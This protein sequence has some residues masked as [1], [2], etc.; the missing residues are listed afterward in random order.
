M[1]F[2]IGLSIYLWDI[3]FGVAIP[4]IFVTLASM[5][6]YTVSTLLPLFYEFC[7]YNTTISKM[8]QQLYQ[9]LSDKGNQPGDENPE[10]DIITGQALCWL[11]V[12][13]E[14][15]RSVDIALQ[16][17]AG[18]NKNLPR[19]LLQEC[20]AEMLIYQR[21]T[22]SSSYAGN[23]D[24]AVSLYARALSFLR[25]NRQGV[26]P[27]DR[28]LETSGKIQVSVWAMQSKNER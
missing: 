23:C 8:G 1:L 16:A 21:L 12:N 7:P 22:A 10:Q 9:T 24:L 14:V 3:N 4:V 15:P 2:A 18:A 6:F 17:I 26:N 25:S 13:C 20:N 27:S 5:G 11:I 28:H 19:E